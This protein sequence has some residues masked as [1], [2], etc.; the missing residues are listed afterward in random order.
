MSVLALTLTVLVGCETPSAPD[1]GAYTTGKSGIQLAN[2]Q[3]SRAASLTSPQ[4]D[5]LLLSAA[6]TYATNASPR[7]AIDALERIDPDQLAGGDAILYRVLAGE[8]A[9]QAR[10]PALAEPLLDAAADADDARRQPAQL[11]VRWHR[12][13]GELFLRRGDVDRSIFELSRAAALETG[14]AATAALHDTIWSALGKLADEQITRGAME[15]SDGIVAGWYSLAAASRGAK[16]DIPRLIESYSDWQQNHPGHPAATTP[17]GSLAKLSSITLARA[18]EIAVLLP[19]SGEYEAAANTLGDGLMAAYYDALAGGASAP[20]LRFYD[21]HNADMVKLYQ[22]VVIEGADVVIGPLEREQLAQLQQLPSLPVPVLG[23]NY[24]EDQ[25]SN[26]DNLY[27]F[28][29][30]IRDEA[31]QI[32]TQAWQAGHRSALTIVPDSR[33]GNSAAE[34]FQEKWRHQGGRLV[35]T[36]TYDGTQNDYAQLLAPTML[37]SE[38]RQRAQRLQR[39]LGKSIS[40]SPRRRGDVDMVMLVSYPDQGRQIKPALDFLYATD[41]P[42]FATSHIYSGIRRPSQDNDLDGIVFTAL[43]WSIRTS[44]ETGITP[45]ANLPTGYKNLFAMGVDAYRL[46]QWLPVL[47]DLTNTEIRG[48]T[49]NLVLVNDNQI[50]RRLPWAEFQGGVARPNAALP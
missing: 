33:T 19:A 23:L 32:A 27:Q 34:A 26:H 10:R 22:R 25:V 21:S 42:V 49:G 5:Q 28:G 43:P 7:R 14:A 9:L 20:Q 30:S 8:L 6:D 37:V 29:L 16:G 1:P 45:P 4:R 13:R 12:A 31:G 46:H 39:V 24:L 48:L 41:L 44:G 11:R 2:E 3:V 35:N 47:K 40:Y 15:S 18:D 50:Q 17:P 36:T 38:S